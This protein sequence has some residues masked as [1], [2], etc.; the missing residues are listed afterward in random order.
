MVT[1]TAA[2]QTL[3]AHMAT[4]MD[5]IAALPTQ[6]REVP[7]PELVRVTAQAEVEESDTTTH[8]IDLTM[9]TVTG[10]AMGPVDVVATG[11][12]MEVAAEVA[13]A[14]DM[15]MDPH[16][17]HHLLRLEDRIQEQVTGTV[18]AAETLVTEILTLEIM[19]EVL[20]V[21]AQVMVDLPELFAPFA[22]IF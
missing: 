13:E 15:A 21:A 11:L 14:T 19:Q 2:D 17:H 6:V 12:T 4:P 22:S 3:V 20:Q 1:I 16:P 10:M 7:E 18:A 5:P 9:D 8:L